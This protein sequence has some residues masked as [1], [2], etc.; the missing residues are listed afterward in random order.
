M[1]CVV[2]MEKVNSTF[3]WCLLAAGPGAAAHNRR[4][5]RRDHGWFDRGWGR[6]LLPMA[7]EKDSFQKHSLFETWMTHSK[8][9]VGLN[10]NTIIV[11]L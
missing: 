7:D 1:S 9:D 5:W 11:V 6:L 4:L 10:K 3:Y 8:Y 2:S